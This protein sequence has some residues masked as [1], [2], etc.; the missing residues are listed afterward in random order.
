M[1]SRQQSVQRQISSPRAISRSA[2]LPTSRSTNSLILFKL[3]Q[4]FAARPN[5]VVVVAKEFAQRQRGA[6]RRDVCQVELLRAIIRLVHRV[7]VFVSRGHITEKDV[8]RHGKLSSLFDRIV[9]EVYFK[10]GCFHPKVWVARYEPKES[11]DA[12]GQ[13]PM[14][15]IICA[16]RNLTQGSRWEI[17][18][19]FEGK[20]N[21]GKIGNGPRGSWPIFLEL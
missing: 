19:A 12:L 6:V 21:G 20:E 2:N 17:F 16:S 10:E 14:V 18:A 4:L 8:A 3:Y 7:R 15:R 1:R 11:A 9:H 5:A 13:K